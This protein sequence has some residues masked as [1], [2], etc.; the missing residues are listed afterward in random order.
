MRP[1]LRVLRAAILA[2]PTALAF[3]S[4]GYFDQAR[5]VA[6][7]VTWALA[8]AAI[9][10]SETPLPRSREGL[11]A[12]GALTGYVAWIGLSTTWAPLKGP[13]GDDFER[14]VLYLGAFIAVA[15]AFR[16]RSAGRARR[17]RLR[18]P[19]AV[20]AGHRARARDR[21]GRRAP[22]PPAH[23]LERRGR[24]RGPRA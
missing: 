7:I 1:V 4:G 22:R 21:V 3:A 11:A 17:H 9:C 5:L 24:A 18:A 8:A 20:A 19:G 2:G 14:A 13:A 15:A 6:L 12:L 16:P 23:L 10:L